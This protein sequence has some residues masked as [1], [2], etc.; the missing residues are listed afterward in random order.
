MPNKLDHD[1]DPSAF[2]SKLEDRGS[3]LRDHWG[4]MFEGR[5]IYVDQPDTDDQMRVKQRDT[6][7]RMKQACN[8]ARFAGAQLTGELKEG[9]THVLVGNDQEHIKSLRRTLSRYAYGEN[10]YMFMWPVP[11]LYSQ[12][13]APPTACHSQLDKAELEGEDSSR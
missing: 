11:N 2:K 4:C 12:F 5:L 7:F 8:I 3:S 9:V 10:A 6:V 1:F 13:Q